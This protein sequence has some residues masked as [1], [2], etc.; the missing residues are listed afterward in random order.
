MPVSKESES[1]ESHTQ[2]TEVLQKE[3]K[4]ATEKFKK[5]HGL[6]T[7]EAF[8]FTEILKGTMTTVLLVRLSLTA[9]QIF[10]A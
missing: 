9:D 3:K 6:M 4:K 10:M 1:R 5:W 7:Y 2:R 8:D